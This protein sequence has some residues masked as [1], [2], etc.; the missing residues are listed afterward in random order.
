MNDIEYVIAPR[1]QVQIIDKVIDKLKLNTTGLVET[2]ND[3]EAILLLFDLF[4]IEHP[5]HF[6]QFV[7]IMKIYKKETTTNNAIVKD[8][9]GDMVQHMLEVPEMFYMYINKMFPN[10]KWDKKFI[11]KLSSELPILKTTDTL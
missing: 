11:L 1:Q 9:E 5:E 6:N 4:K 2:Q 3:W 8:G 7:E 10:Q